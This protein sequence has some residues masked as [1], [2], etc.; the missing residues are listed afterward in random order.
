M[1]KNVGSLISRK[2]LFQNQSICEYLLLISTM[3]I[4][5]SLAWV[6]GG[7]NN[8]KMHKAAQ[9]AADSELQCLNHKLIINRDG[10]SIVVNEKG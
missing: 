1:H 9:E 7:L 4:L 10:L 6:P 8:H 3:R 2:I 5:S